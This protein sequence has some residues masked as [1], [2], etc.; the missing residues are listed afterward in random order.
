MG[1]GIDLPA[2]KFELAH[3]ADLD[4]RNAHRRARL[5]PAR[6]L[7]CHVN[8]ERRLETE[9]AHHHHERGE[10][11]ERHQDQRAY[12]DFDGPLAH[13]I[14]PSARPLMNCTITGSSVLLKSAG[15]PSSL[16]FPL[17][18]ITMRSAMPKIDGK[19]W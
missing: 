2:A 8:R 6:V 17:Y 15:V 18:S 11:P 4:A 13:S 7:K 9:A 1:L 3:S 14:G 5:Q 19:S 12:F 10:Q 16:T